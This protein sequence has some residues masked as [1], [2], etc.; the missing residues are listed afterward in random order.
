MR[1]PRIL[2]ASLLLWATATQAQEAPADGAEQ[3]QPDDADRALVNGAPWQAEI[4]SN[5]AGYSAQERAER[6]E[7]ELAHRCGGSLIAADWVLT[8]A[9]CIDQEQVD[10]GYRVRLGTRDLASDNGVTYRI[11]RMVRHADYDAQRHLNDVALVHIA[12]DNET[13]SRYAGHI[14]PI[15]LNGSDDGDAPVGDAI[16][17]SATGWGKTAPGANGH[18]SVG[19]LQVDLTTSSCDAAPAYRGRTTGDMLCAS[20]PGADTCQGD[21]GGPLILTYG[22]PVL[23][24]IVS[25]GDGCADATRPGVYVRIDRDHYLDWIGRAMA[26]DPSINTLD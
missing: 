12:A 9:H 24:G 7:W 17:V 2:A 23:V 14:A 3:S 13:D 10:K 4:Y 5:F 16:A 20:A 21:S 18:A 6:E 1:I 26:A 19:L 8:A 22:E 11:D 15:R 25:W